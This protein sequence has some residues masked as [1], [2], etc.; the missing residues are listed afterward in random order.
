MLLI[1]ELSAKSEDKQKAMLAVNS[2]MHFDLFQSP[3]H[4]FCAFFV[5]VSLALNSCE[6]LPQQIFTNGTAIDDQD[7]SLTRSMIDYST[8]QLLTD[9]AIP[10]PQTMMPF[11]R[12]AFSFVLRMQG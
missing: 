1:S 3:L 12:V 5:I 4:V 8:L 9:N 6:F 2:G 7:P 11:S 10:S